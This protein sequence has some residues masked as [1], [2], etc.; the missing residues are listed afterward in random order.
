MPGEKKPPGTFAPGGGNGARTPDPDLQLLARIVSHLHT[1]AHLTL[2]Q[3]GLA[4]PTSRQSKPLQAVAPRSRSRQPT[5][6][7][8]CSP[9]TSLQPH[10]WGMGSNATLLV[11]AESRDRVQYPMGVQTLG[12]AR[13]GVRTKL[14]AGLEGAASDMVTAK[15][16]GRRGDALRLDRRIGTRRWDAGTGCAP[17]IARARSRR[18]QGLS[19]LPGSVWCSALVR[20]F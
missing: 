10:P 20:S 12:N 14:V 16:R 13:A 9:D 8:W 6:R 18:R 5:P 4:F 15:R 2:Q 19:C 7:R 1:H 3:A 17:A 11:E